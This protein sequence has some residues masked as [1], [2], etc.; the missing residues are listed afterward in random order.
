MYGEPGGLQGE[1]TL[2]QL[3]SEAGY[4]TQAV[5]KWHLGENVESQP[6]N[7]GFDD[8]YGFLSVSDMYS[9]WRDPAFFPEIVYSEART[10]W[11]RNMPFNKCFVHAT[12]GGAAE[13]VEE[14]TIP[15]LSRLDDM[16]CDYSTALHPPHG[17]LGASRGSSITARAAPTSTTTR[18]S[19]SSAPR[20]RATR[21]R[22]RSSSWTTSSAG[23]CA[24]WRPPASSS[25]R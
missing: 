18:S 13:N 8:F 22:T 4:A 16:W 24:S 20:R 1:V 25:T 19:A 2:A 9:E 10:E 6:Q 5:G 7:V 14:V 11:M 12:R 17:G 21:T 15:V 3:L 23:S